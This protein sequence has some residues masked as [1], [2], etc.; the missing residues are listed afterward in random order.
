MSHLRVTAACFSVKARKRKEQEQLCY[1]GSL[2]LEIEH[3]RFSSFQTFTGKTAT[4]F[5]TCFLAI[6]GSFSL[7]PLPVLIEWE[8]L[9]TSDQ[10]EGMKL[11]PQ[12]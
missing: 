8:I 12:R 4:S 2:L 6:M 1:S 10:T 5:R 3:N 7:Y 9:A 11:K